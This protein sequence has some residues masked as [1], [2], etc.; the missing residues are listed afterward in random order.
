[1]SPKFGSS[2]DLGPHLPEI[3][4]RFLGISREPPPADGD[5]IDNDEHTQAMNLSHNQCRA[6]WIVPS[7]AAW[8]S[9]AWHGMAWHGGRG[10]YTSHAAERHLGT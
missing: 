8:H 2:S 9:M 6:H 3:L 5:G 10:H 1:V 7:Q 4:P